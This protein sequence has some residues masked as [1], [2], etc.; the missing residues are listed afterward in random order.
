MWPGYLT[1]L[2]RHMAEDKVLLSQW[3]KLFQASRAATP[4]VGHD[5][6]VTG[7]GGRSIQC[8]KNRPHKL[9]WADNFI[10]TRLTPDCWKLAWLIPQPLNLP[11]GWSIAQLISSTN[12]N[13]LVI[14]SELI[15]A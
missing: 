7:N 14:A 1:P 9:S 2:Q 15:A 3:D 4:N 5:R 13:Q 11:N 6:R 12:V 10:G 8:R